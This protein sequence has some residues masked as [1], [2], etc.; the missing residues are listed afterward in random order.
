MGVEL[1]GPV[2]IQEARPYSQE[3]CLAQPA[4]LPDRHRLSQLAERY[5]VKRVWARDMWHLNSR[6]LR[7]VLSHTFAFLLNHRMGNHPCSS[8]SCSF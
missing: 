3:E 1:F 2:L 7:K 5:S 6:L 4:S 8:P